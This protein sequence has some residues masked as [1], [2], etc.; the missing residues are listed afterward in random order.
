MYADLDLTNIKKTPPPKPHQPVI[1]FPQRLSTMYPTHTED[2]S[3]AYSTVNDS[4]YSHPRVPSQARP[5]TTYD[6]ISVY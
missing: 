3:V 5:T 1:S 2:K 6:I 4:P